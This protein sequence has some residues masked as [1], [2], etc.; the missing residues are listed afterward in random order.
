MR[1]VRSALRPVDSVR[2]HV[3]PRTE[4][5]L[6][7]NKRVKGRAEEHSAHIS[8]KWA[9]AYGSLI[10][11]HNSCQLR[12]APPVMGAVDRRHL[13]EFNATQPH[14]HGFAGG[15]IAVLRIALPLPRSGHAEHVR[16][17]LFQCTAHRVAPLRALNS[18]L[19]NQVGKLLGL[20]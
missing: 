3:R 4:S 7:G 13:N 2:V 15:A 9:N 16:R 19:A 10:R 12:S 8:E 6:L 5:L 1:L 20:L 14:G 17:G 11:R 18:K